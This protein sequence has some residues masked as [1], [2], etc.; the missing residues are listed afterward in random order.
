MTDACPSIYRCSELKF[1]VDLARGQQ[2]RAWARSHMAPDPHGSG[3]FGDEYHTTSLYFDTASFDVFHRRGSFGR[4]K[5]RIRRYGDGDLVFLERKLRRPNLL[6]KRRALVPMADLARLEAPP[7]GY[8]SG[9]WFEKRR[10]ARRLDPVC[11]VS[12]DR[13]ARGATSD[14]GTARLTLDGAIRVHSTRQV[15]FSGE[16][17]IPLL[18]DALILE[19]KFRDSM[20]ALFKGL[21]EDLKLQP[22]RAS[23]YR[24]GLAALSPAGL[25]EHEALVEV[26][27]GAHA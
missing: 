13:M 5:Y 9:H 17:G 19:L 14:G 24:L 1:V 15:R 2:I 6:V 18:P 21:I 4:A 10:A 22:A 26:E 27:P 7:D 20:P 11:Q 3:A 12:Y 8:W 16:P 23:K 25:G